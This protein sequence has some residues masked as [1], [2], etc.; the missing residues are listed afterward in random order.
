MREALGEVPTKITELRGVIRDTTHFEKEGIVETM[1]IP[2]DHP[3]KKYLIIKKEQASLFP[4][5]TLEV[6][7][8][9]KVLVPETEVKKYYLFHERLAR[10]DQ[11]VASS[12][13]FDLVKTTAYNISDFSDEKLHEV[14]LRFVDKFKR[15]PWLL[16]YSADQDLYPEE[17]IS[18]LAQSDPLR[19][20]MPEFTYLNRFRRRPKA[21]SPYQREVA[22]LAT[23][24]QDNYEDIIGGREYSLPPVNIIEDDPI[25]ILNIQRMSEQFV[26]IVTDDVKLCRLAARKFPEKIL[27]RISVVDWVFHS[28][29]YSGFLNA[30]KTVIP[31]TTEIIIDQGSLE[32]YMETNLMMP[33]ANYSLGISTIDPLQREWS[34]DVYRLPMPTQSQIYAKRRPRATVTRENV[35][36]K[37][38]ILSRMNSILSRAVYNPPITSSSG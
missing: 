2:Q 26:I 4:P 31:V 36:D 37:I 33:V 24:F 14:V 19:V 1:E 10:L 6:L 22:N 27:G 15:S 13:L 20:R 8:R 38:Q 29:D 7:Q 18:I 30:I 16:R 9:N 12:D 3:I 11:V 34:G 25:I 35:L 17:L 28:M 21:D 23:W 5:G 32:T